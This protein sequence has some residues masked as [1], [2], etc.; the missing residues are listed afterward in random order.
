MSNYF[1][2]MEQN[3]VM[4]FRWNDVLLG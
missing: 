2:V 1:K 3:I 4:K